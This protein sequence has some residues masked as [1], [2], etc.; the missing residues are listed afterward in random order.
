MVQGTSRH[1]RH[2]VP[3]VLGGAPPFQGTLGTPPLG[4]VPVCLEGACASWA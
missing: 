4:G 1:N 3:N 2:I